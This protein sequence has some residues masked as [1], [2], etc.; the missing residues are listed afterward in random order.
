MEALVVTMQL[1]RLGYALYS[2]S[3]HS[4]ELLS[5]TTSR[6]C[7]ADAHPLH[8]TSILAFA[9]IKTRAILDLSQP[10]ASGRHNC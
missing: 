9:G 1:S 4:P 10:N 5:L 6:I 2:L 7:S 8:N 3:C